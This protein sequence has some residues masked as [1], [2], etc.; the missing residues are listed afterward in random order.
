MLVVKVIL[1][2]NIAQPV[3]RL[4]DQHTL[5]RTSHEVSMPMNIPR[6]VH[7]RHNFVQEIPHLIIGA[8]GAEL[9]DPDGQ[10]IGEFACGVDV[11]FEVLGVARPAVPGR[12]VVS[13]IESRKSGR[14][15]DLH[16]MGEKL[17]SGD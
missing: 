3:S 5:T 14:N 12:L 4:I 16:R 1:L 17:T 15:R 2:T 13:T 9:G 8:I 7:P 6:I 11:V 10:T